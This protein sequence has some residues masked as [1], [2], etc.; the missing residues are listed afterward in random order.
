MHNTFLSICIPTY[1]RSSEIIKR[2]EEI[3]TQVGLIDT[4]PNIEIV[5][6]DNCSSDDTEDKVKN[7]KN[8][9]QNLKITYSK[10]Q[11]NLGYGKNIN[12]LI[13][14]ASGKY[15]WLCGDDDKINDLA[16]KNL[17][18][19]LTVKAPNYLVLNSSHYDLKTKLF[20]EK[21]IL[22][23]IDS[24]F[25]NSSKVLDEYFEII[26]FIGSN[27]FRKDL[28]VK[29]LEE[30]GNQVSDVYQNS[31]LSFLIINNLDEVYISQYSYVQDTLGNKNYTT[32]QYLDV[33]ILEYIKLKM[34]VKKYH[35][36]AFN[37]YLNNKIYRH[38]KLYGYKI[39]LWK[40]FRNQKVFNLY[41]EVWMRREFLNLKQLFLV[42]LFILLALTPNNVLKFLLLLALQFKYDKYNK[43]RD[44]VLS[45][46]DKKM[47]TYMEDS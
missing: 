28:A 17:L 46:D 38:I 14:L 1:N 33:P 45:L 3:S 16:I 40:I 22:K 2:L 27:V 5:I 9:Y 41:Y 47:T 32:R 25:V 29:A 43:I 37:I 7:F 13:E 12:K 26:V 21:N 44:E 31:L 39:L 18:D 23:N 36:N 11:K 24:Q 42:L 6:S 19:I 15:I 30:L 20:T 10:N 4:L 35:N 34:L 8:D